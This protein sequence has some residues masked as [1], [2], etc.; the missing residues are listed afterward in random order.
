MD[1]AKHVLAIPMYAT[2][3]WLIWVLDRQI[4]LNGTLLMGAFCLV[5][6][7]VLFAKKRVSQS[8]FKTL[9]GFL[10]GVFVLLGCFVAFSP[11]TTAL[12]THT[13]SDIEEAV[14]QHKKVFVDVTAAWCITCKVNEETVLNTEEIQQLFAK[15]GVQKI[16]LDWTNYDEEITGF[17]EKHGRVGVPLYIYYNESGD[18]TILPQVLTKD[19]V[20]RL[21]KS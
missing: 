20:K 2:V 7:A 8:V 17:L 11:T 18:A 5:I 9:L 21:V 15:E 13:V 10:L 3:L 4:Q 6:L 14:Q 19:I 16:V 12:S 1:K